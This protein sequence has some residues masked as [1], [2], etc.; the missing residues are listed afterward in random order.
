MEVCVSCAATNLFLV[1]QTTC[2]KHS[3]MYHTENL[4]CVAK[5]CYRDFLVGKK[6]KC[7]KQRGKEHSRSTCQSQWRLGPLGRCSGCWQFI[8]WQFITKNTSTRQLLP[9]C[10]SRGIAKCS[11]S[12]IP[13]PRHCTSSFMLSI[14]STCTWGW[15]DPPCPTMGS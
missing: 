8:L 4:Q 15:G 1:P 11:S 7:K 5:I 12:P 14:I 3:N 10:L 13:R 9:R 2:G 6:K